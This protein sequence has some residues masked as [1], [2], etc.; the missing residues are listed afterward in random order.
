MKF[1]TDLPAL[2]A[3]LGDLVEREV[4]SDLALEQ[5]AFF[6]M[7][8]LPLERNHPGPTVIVQ[9]SSFIVDFFIHLLNPAAQQSQVMCTLGRGLWEL[10]VHLAFASTFTADV[11]T[12]LTLVRFVRNA[13]DA[14]RIIGCGGI[15]GV[16]VSRDVTRKLIVAEVDD[17]TQIEFFMPAPPAAGNQSSGFCSIIGSK[18]L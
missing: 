13:G 1:V 12:E 15:G 7:P 18:L 14:G 17:L 8:P 16:M 6:A 11:Q 2:A 9:R 5:I 4:T 3:K 10:D